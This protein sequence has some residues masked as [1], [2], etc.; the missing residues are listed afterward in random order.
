MTDRPAVSDYVAVAIILTATVVGL[1][2]FIGAAAPSPTSPFALIPP[3]VSL[4]ALT[5]VVLVLTAVVRNLAVFRGTASARYYRDY[6]SDAPGET[7]ERPAR[8]FNNLLQ[9]PTLFYAACALMLASGII[10]TVQVTLAWLFVGLR[11]LHA[12]VYIAFN[13]LAYRFSLFAA[14]CVVLGVLWARL[15][16]QSWPG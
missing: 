10:D 13:R 15:A 2:L 9:M 16:I 11:V 7:I 14:S 6:V 12:F 1:A 4:V 3:V 5:F 8:A